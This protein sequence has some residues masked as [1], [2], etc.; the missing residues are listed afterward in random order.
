MTN[1]ANRFS[2]KIS[3][4]GYIE[5]TECD[6]YILYIA[7]RQTHQ[8]LAYRQRFQSI[9][10]FDVPV[11]ATDDLVIYQKGSSSR[12]L[13]FETGSLAELNFEKIIQTTKLQDSPN[14]IS[15]I[16]NYMARNHV[17]DMTKQLFVF[18]FYSSE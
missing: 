13:V 3:Q 11:Y 16:F 1:N 14:A 15:D 9:N 10:T 7:F 17:W 12:E 18:L 2:D 5:P 8:M 6:R 4:E